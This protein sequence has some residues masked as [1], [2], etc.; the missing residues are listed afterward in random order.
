LDFLENPGNPNQTKNGF[1]IAWIWSMTKSRNG[2]ANS[3]TQNGT[4]PELND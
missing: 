4:N 3:K 2:T 1:F